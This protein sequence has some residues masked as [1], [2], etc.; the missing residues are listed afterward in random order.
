MDTGKVSVSKVHWKETISDSLTC[1]TRGS[2]FSSLMLPV[3]EPVGPSA[4]WPVKTSL[5]AFMFGDCRS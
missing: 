1:S 4:D 5:C 3:S 2:F